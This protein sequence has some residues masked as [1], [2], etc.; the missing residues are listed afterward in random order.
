ML[1]ASEIKLPLWLVQHRLERGGR[2]FE[3]K[4]GLESR[5]LS[6]SKPTTKINDTTEPMLDRPALMN[7]WL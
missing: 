2:V 6:K 4:G 3:P 5:A 1:S 7:G